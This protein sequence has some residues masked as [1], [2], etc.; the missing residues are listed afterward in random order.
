MRF[1]FYHLHEIRN[2]IET[3]VSEG[4]FPRP[5]HQDCVRPEGWENPNVRDRPE[6]FVSATFDDAVRKGRGIPGAAELIQSVLEFR[7]EPG[8]DQGFAQ[9]CCPSESA[10]IAQL[11]SDLQALLDAADPEDPMNHIY[12]QEVQMPV[13]RFIRYTVWRDFEADYGPAGEIPSWNDMREP[14]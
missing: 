2:R 5:H 10:R 6:D 1:T 9:I 12:T 3:D 4:R 11:E 13:V 8:T 14:R 7:R